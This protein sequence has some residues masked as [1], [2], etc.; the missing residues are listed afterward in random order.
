MLKWDSEED[1][2]QAR[3]AFEKWKGFHEDAIQSN[4]LKPRLYVSNAFAF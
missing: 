1:H 3:E 2:Q 4:D